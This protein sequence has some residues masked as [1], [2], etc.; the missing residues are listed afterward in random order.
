MREHD[1]R[2][3]L[4]GEGDGGIGSHVCAVTDGGREDTER[5]AAMGGIVPDFLE[6]CSLSLLIC[7]D[8]ARFISYMQSLTH[9]HFHALPKIIETTIKRRRIRGKL[10]PA[11]DRSVLNDHSRPGSTTCRGRHRP[12]VPAGETEGRVRG[13]RGGHSPGSAGP[14]PGGRLR[15]G[16]PSS[17]PGPRGRSG[18]PGARPPPAGRPPGASPGSGRG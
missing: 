13:P 1:A 3:R 5:Q 17:G 8:D 18:W 14:G 2:R 12:T 7:R 10:R 16:R 11:S 9:S 6:T 15:N 4:R